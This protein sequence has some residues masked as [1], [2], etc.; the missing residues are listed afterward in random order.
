MKI[1]IVGFFIILLFI[2][3]IPIVYAQVSIDEKAKQKTVNVTI[4]ELNQIHVKHEVISSNSP[5]QLQLING[6]INNLS[7]TDVEGNERQFGSFGN[8]DGIIIFPSEK[9]IVVEYD[10]EDVLV[11]KN[12]VWTLNF[13]YLQTT[14]FIFPKEVD[15]VFANNKPVYLGENVGIACHGCQMILE[16]SINEPKILKNI[17]YNNK[18]FLVEIRSFAELDKFNFNQLTKEINFHVKGEKQFVTVVVPIQLLP[19]SYNVLV[20][21]E[22]IYFHGYINNG[23]HVWINIRSDTTGMVSIIDTESIEQVN[24]NIE[25]LPIISSMN[26]NIIALLAVLI[27]IGVVVTIIIMKK[28]SLID[29]KGIEHNH[30]QDTDKI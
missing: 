24:Y 25:D 4:N 6:T 21:N 11:L 17:E 29:S 10:L 7:V 14:N 8:N 27:L 20:D 23:T 15:L 19:E 3:S 30:T 12:N 28:K 16:Y 1:K 18:D 5:K 26:Q 9:N 2:I 13:R 22:K